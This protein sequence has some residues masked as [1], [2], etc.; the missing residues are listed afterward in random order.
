MIATTIINSISVK[1]FWIVFMVFAS[2]GMV[3]KTA[4]NLA[5]G[6]D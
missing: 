2:L 6:K 5:V 1:P 4:G 3:Q